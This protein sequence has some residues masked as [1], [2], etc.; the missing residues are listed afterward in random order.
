[1]GFRTEARKFVVDKYLWL[2]GE[3]GPFNCYG[4]R[5]LWD[6]LRRKISNNIGITFEPSGENTRLPGGM[7]A[8]CKQGLV[9]R[10]KYLQ[11][12]RHAV[13]GEWSA[14]GWW[15]IFKV[16]PVYEAKIGPGVV[17]TVDRLARWE[18]KVTRMVF[19]FKKEEDETWANCCTRA[20]RFARKIWTKMGLPSVWSDRRMFVEPWDG[21]VTKDPMRWHWSR[22]FRRR[23]TRWWQSTQATGMK[24]DP[25]NH[26]RWKHMWGWHNRGCVWDEVATEWA[27][28]EDWI[29]KH[30]RQENIR[31]LCV[32]ECQTFDDTQDKNW[33]KKKETDED[34]VPRILDP[35][36]Q[37]NPYSWR[38][39]DSAALRI[40]WGCG[41]VDQ[42]PVCSGSTIPSLP[43]STTM[44]KAMSARFLRTSPEKEG[45]TD[46]SIEEGT[47]GLT[48]RHR[49]RLLLNQEEKE[50]AMRPV[51]PWH[52]PLHGRCAYTHTLSIGSKQGPTP[53]QICFSHKL[54]RKPTPAIAGHPSTRHS[55][56]SRSGSRRK[57]WCLFECLREVAPGFRCDARVFL[58]LCAGTQ[59][60]ARHETLHGAEAQVKHRIVPAHALGEKSDCLS[61]F[62]R[63]TR[64]AGSS[65][66]KIRSIRCTRRTWT[67]H[68]KTTYPHP[69]EWSRHTRGALLK[70][71]TC[72]CVLSQVFSWNTSRTNCKARD[73]VREVNRQDMKFNIASAPAGFDS[74]APLEPSTG[75][76]NDCL[77]TR[78][79]FFLKKKTKIKQDQ[80]DCLARLQG[81]PPPTLLFLRSSH[82]EMMSSESV[83]H[84]FVPTHKR[85]VLCGSVTQEQTHCACDRLLVH[86]TLACP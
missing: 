18:T 16:S 35:G 41:E 40:R 12:Q 60:P 72:P 45:G 55:A 38:W 48:D 85:L 11:K 81:A 27:G 73:L 24:N 20:A 47:E 79:F 67:L 82:S 10:C 44:C 28:N 86:V 31:Y 70:T 39:T 56:C 80:C 76:R 37:N 78:D 9:E 25:Y 5:T 52:I 30:W 69:Y 8:K 57:P 50:L 6:T 71:D 14:K 53:S 4:D 62:A 2:R 13:E 51:H 43:S 26:T 33:E 19:R 61:R 3:E 32:V 65:M 22:F 59:K 1:M 21:S 15:N 23:S 58:H 75:C 42:R 34:K 63:F 46:V 66:W 17:A 83:Q 84:L 77:F 54:W 7:E 36:G 29:C 74:P 68:Q 49:R 64:G